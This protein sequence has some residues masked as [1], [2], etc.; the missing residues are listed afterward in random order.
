M[1]KWFMLLNYGW[2]ILT[3]LTAQIKNYSNATYVAMWTAMCPKLKK[4]KKTNPRVINT[5]LQSHFLFVLFS[6]FQL[7]FSGNDHLKKIE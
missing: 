1:S 7:N 4:K 2:K 6:F 3:W 5:Y